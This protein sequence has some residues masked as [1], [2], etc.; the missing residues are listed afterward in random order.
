MRDYP[1]P[2][3]NV[4]TEHF[5]DTLHIALQLLYAG[6]INRDG[7]STLY[8]SDY[9]YI[10]NTYKENK[11]SI[12]TLTG[13]NNVTNF[14]KII[15]CT[16]PIVEYAEKTKIN[17]LPIPRMILNEHSD[18][19]SKGVC[20]KESRSKPQKREGWKKQNKRKTYD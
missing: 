2:L 18:N 16:T 13:F 5:N 7:I 6:K 4:S 17:H 19:R 1:I 3:P 11:T 12:I 8:I 10:Y 20:W 9:P 14:R 15:E